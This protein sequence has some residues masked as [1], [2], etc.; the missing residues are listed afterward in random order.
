MR[1]KTISL[2]ICMY[3]HEQRTSHNPYLDGVGKVTA[4]ELKHSKAEAPTDGFQHEICCQQVQLEVGRTLVVSLLP[5]HGPAVEMSGE[6]NKIQ[7]H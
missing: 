5:C 6:R 4:A 2:L 3:L 1:Q 7:I